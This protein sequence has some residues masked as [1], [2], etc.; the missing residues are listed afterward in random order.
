M[1]KARLG[2]LKLTFLNMSSL[3]SFI[4]Y[5]ALQILL[6]LHEK[7]VLKLPDLILSKVSILSL[8]I[9][10]FLVISIFARLTVN[11][12]YGFFDEREEKIFYSKTY[13]ASLYILGVF[14]ILYKLGVSLGNITLVIGIL[15]TGL[16]FTVREVLLAYFSWMV[17]LRKKP[18]RIGDYIRIGEDEGKV[19]HIGTFYVL[20]DKTPELP[21]DYVRVP[22]KQFLDKSVVNFGTE[23]YHEKIKLQLNGIPSNKKEL[24]SL[25]KKDI[26]G[27]GLN[28][29]YISVMTDVKDGALFLIIEYL[30]SFKRQRGMRSEVIDLAFSRFKKY[31]VIPD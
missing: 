14:Y 7:E 13:G 1:V 2:E 24:I 8:F 20:L 6:Y 23:N 28:E 18:F 4:A 31:I 21:E 5:S 15:A 30:V 29:E 19:Q 11:R 25:L 9:I 27:A 16:A 12:V 22:N 10:T 3:I 26:K 17:L